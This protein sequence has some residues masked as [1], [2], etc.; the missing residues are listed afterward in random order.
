MRA[1]TAKRSWAGLKAYPGH[2][3]C[4]SPSSCSFVV[5]A[6]SS[7]AACRIQNFAEVRSRASPFARP[8]GFR[9]SRATGAALHRA[10]IEIRD[11][12]KGVLSVPTFHQ[13]VKQ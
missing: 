9:K 3:R 2:R 13:L 6:V 12:E 4:Y 11:T 10:R 7:T 1:G 5:H 8:K